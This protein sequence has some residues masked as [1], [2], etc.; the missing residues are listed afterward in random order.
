MT[1][2]NM[3]KYA[4][5]KKAHLKMK[6][7]SI[8]SSKKSVLAL[9]IAAFVAATSIVPSYTYAIETASAE[10]RTVET[11]TVDNIRYEIINSENFEVAAVYY[12]MRYTSLTVPGT[13]EYNGQE[14]KVTT[15]PNGAFDGQPNLTEIVISEGVK[16]VGLTAF[17]SCPKVETISLPSTLETWS[18][19]GFQSLKTINIAE[20]NKAFKLIDGILFNSNETKL[21]LYPAQKEGTEYTI[22]ATVTTIG[23]NSFYHNQYLETLNIHDGVT[24]IEDYAFDSFQSLKSIEIGE[25]VTYFGRWNLYECPNLEN[26]IYSSDTEISNFSI[27]YCPKL[28]SITFNGSIEEISASYA[29]YALDNLEKYIITDNCTTY[30]EKDGVL[31][32]GTELVRYPAG[33]Q[34]NTYVVPD[35]TTKIGILAFNNMQYTTE[36]I[37]PEGVLVYDQSFNYPNRISPIDIYFRDKEA[38]SLGKQKSGVFVGLSEGSNLYVRNEKV[39]DSLNSYQYAI[40][41]EIGNED[42]VSKSIKQIAISDIIFDSETVNLIVGEEKTITPT[43][44][45]YYHTEEITWDSSNEEIATVIDGKITGVYPGTALITVSSTGG[46]TKT[47]E[48]NIKAPL[49]DIYLSRNEITIQKGKSETL[50]VNYNPVYTTDDKTVI[51]ESSDNSIAT[52]KNGEI[53]A[54]GEGTVTITARVGSHIATCKATVSHEHKYVRTTTKATLTENGS[55]KEICEKCK[56][57]KLVSTIYKPTTFKINDSNLVFD[58]EAH[59]PAITI[60]DANG[61]VISTDNYTIRY[62]ENCINAGEYKAYI[63]FKGNYSGNTSKTFNIEKALNSWTQSLKIENWLYG[64]TPSNPTASSFIGDVTYKYFS[65]ADCTKEITKPTEPGTYYVKAFVTEMDNYKALESEPVQ[66]KIHKTIDQTIK[67]LNLVYAKEND[68]TYVKGFTLGT[69]VSA[70]KNNLNGLDSARLV[71]FTN[72][73]GTEITSGPVATGMKFTLEINGVRHTKTI[74]VMGDVNGDGN[75]KATDYMKIKNHIMNPSAKLQ[76]E[77]Y[78]AADVNGDGNIKATDYMKIKNH[79]MG[80]STIK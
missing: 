72:N 46:L 28:T 50:S 79:I 24:I 75:I 18:T 73:K 30:Q 4:K 71:S 33:K 65:D 63:D 66:F 62:D 38:V 57:E 55:V 11:F 42:W 41:S 3:K 8:I 74:V 15:I 35:G 5:K 34:T 56:D 27:S 23:D 48:A 19:E 68:T 64:E 16:Y 51:W 60:I 2:T 67:S 1:S 17:R 59:N 6:R 80:T 12:P 77:Y 47:I 25:N 49:K 76:D 22:P 54:V 45:P 37:L 44:K 53:T 69:D 31:Y 21:C 9:Y 61:E 29:L 52:V 32:Q 39:L 78:L 26:V 13:V 43:L 10:T 58:G 14:Y 20:N 70:I 7:N 40:C 36:I